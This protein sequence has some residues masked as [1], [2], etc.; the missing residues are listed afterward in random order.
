MKSINSIFKDKSNILNIY[1]TA[2]FPTLNS[3]VDLIKELDQAGV[4]LIEVGVPYS[5]PLADGTTIQQSSEHALKNGMKLHI[6]FDQLKSI[7][8]DVK[9]PLIMMGYFNQMLQ[10]GPEKYL[11]NCVESGVSG[12]I[13]PDIPMPVYESEYKAMFEKYG[14][15]MCFLITPFTSEERIRKADE[16]STGFI[17]VVSQTSI[18]G[19]T[20]KISDE[21][22]A[23]FNRINEMQLKT[24][25]LI[26]FG[27]HNKET[28]DL[29]CKYSQGGIIGS[30]FI[31]S[32]FGKEEVNGAA[33]A[34]VESVRG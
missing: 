15:E 30:A 4:D 33:T 29:A 27:I 14:I 22:I 10:F 31:R 26:G 3:T 17:Y 13:I 8:D 25:K 18:T 28:F 24:P 19:N 23:Y 21:Q 7:K 5:D 12:L 20:G 9:C 32:L 34:F 1:I 6:L 11:Q 16:L 2:G